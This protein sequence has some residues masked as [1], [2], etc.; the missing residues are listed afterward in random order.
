VQRLEEEINYLT[1]IVQLEER[2]EEHITKHW[3]MC[4]SQLA[5]LANGAI[6]DVPRMLREADVSLTFRTV[7]KEVETFLD[8]C[9]WLVGLMKNMVARN[10]N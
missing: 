7:P 4:F 3:K 5:A 9:K 6:E 8:H 2:L 10:K 1:Q